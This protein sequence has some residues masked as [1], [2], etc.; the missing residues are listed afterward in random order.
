M[1][2]QYDEIVFFEPTEYMSNI[3]KGVMKV[4]P[5]PEPIE[6][7]GKIKEVEQ[8]DAPME[9]SKEIN[10]YELLDK[11]K[12]TLKVSPEDDTEVD[13]QP[14]FQ[15]FSDQNDLRLLEMGIKFIS[16]EIVALKDAS[17]RRPA[18]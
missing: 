12:Y 5:V 6:E 18:G 13:I 15:T 14:Y 3:L 8:G 10:P 7:E 16:E 2:E 9:D 17:K 4:E 1:N 11:G